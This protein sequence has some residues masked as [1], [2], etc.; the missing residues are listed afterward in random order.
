MRKQVIFTDKLM[1]PIA[2]FSHAVRVGQMI[3]VGAT[4]GTDAALQ[5]AGSK[6]GYVDAAAQTVRMFDNLATVLDI[7]GGSIADLV[8]AKVYVVDPRDIRQVQQIS[9]TRLSDARAAQALVGSHGFPL[10][11]AAIELDAIAI[12]NS[13]AHKRY[14]AETSHIH[15]VRVGKRFYG[16]ATPGLA[17]RDAALSFPQQ[18]D[19]AF[20]TLIDL[21]TQAGLGAADLVSLHVTLAHV[22]ETALFNVW[23]KKVLGDQAV[24]VTVVIAPLPDPAIRVQ[25]EAFAWAGGGRRI[26]A[27]A[28]EVQAVLA[29]DEIH[30]GGSLGYERP[31]NLPDGAERQIDA[32]WSNIAAMLELAGSGAE[33]VLRTNNILTDWR[34]YAGFNRGYGKHVGRPFP[35][36]TTILAGLAAP[37]ARIQIAG[38]VY[39]GSEDA[40]FVDVKPES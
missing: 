7:L 29:G 1:R 18:I 27:P 40:T 20:A 31:G 24:A 19:R 36:R 9:D 35:P 2:H 32:A 13:G 26:P 37:D 10:P 23:S 12:L 11:Q 22:A 34:D 38:I 6:P 39:C 8:N 30:F 21:L 3:Y 5:L 4:A 15:A 25:F 14:L 28:G 33:N 17:S 16:T